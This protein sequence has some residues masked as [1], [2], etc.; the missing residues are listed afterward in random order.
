MDP[1][2]MRRSFYRSMTWFLT[3]TA[4]MVMA[5]GPAASDEIVPRFGSASETVLRVARSDDGLKFTDTSRPFAVRAAGPDLTVLPNGH[6]LVLFDYAF[7]RE[8]AERTLLAASRSK[9][10]GQTWS[11]IRMVR[12]RDTQ[13]RPVAGRPWV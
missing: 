10:G 7:D 1:E 8:S 11:P 4:A 5:A 13:G 6:L 12:V 9:D 2:S 3:L